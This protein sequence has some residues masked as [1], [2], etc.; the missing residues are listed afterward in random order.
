M[1]DEDRAPSFTAV[2]AV[3]TGSWKSRTAATEA[4]ATAMESGFFNH[5]IP[6]IMKKTSILTLVISIILTLL[7]IYSLFFVKTT[8]T[9]TFTNNNETVETI[10]VV[11]GETIKL[12]ENP[13]EEGK[14]FIGWYSN[15]K[16]VTNKT[17]VESNM[18]VE[19]KFEE[20][21]T[22]TKKASKKK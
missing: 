15:G 3:E 19:A 6:I 14:K 21:T 12:P 2:A 16:E 22:T 17:V 20:I 11:K 4:A 5:M 7:F 9:V 10:K 1:V 8:F 18:K 13:T